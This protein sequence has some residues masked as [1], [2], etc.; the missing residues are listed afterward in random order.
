MHE[1]HNPCLNFLLHDVTINVYMFG[2]SMKT[3]LDAMCVAAWLSQNK[4]DGPSQQ[5]CNS[6][7]KEITHNVSHV[8]AVMV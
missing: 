7:S 4:V 2:A 5:T 8:E 1:L 6:L 3:E